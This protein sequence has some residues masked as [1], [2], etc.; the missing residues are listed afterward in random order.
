MALIPAGTFQM[1]SNDG[2]ED[3]RPVHAVYL[4][5]FYMDVY[6]V[7]NAQYKKFLDATP[8]SRAPNQWNNPKFN[9]SN[10]PVVGVTWFEAVSYAEWVGERLPTEA[11][12]EK[13][14]RGG[15]IGKQYP[16]GDNLTHNNANFIGIGA[17][18]IWDDQTSPVGSFPPNGYGLYD[19]IGNVWEWCSGWYS[20]IYYV[21]SP[22]QNPKGPGSGNNR[23]LRGSFWL[24]NIPVDLRVS[25]R[26]KD[27]P[28]I[29]NPSVGFRCV[30]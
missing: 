17:N 25:G 22:K 16:W 14:A 4:D 13:A 9:A 21:N 10:Q 28:A 27:I 5:A 7:T 12:W 20:G 6:E 19:M 24:H 23:V 15:L 18:D 8:G 2:R 26:W 30:R 3:E 29:D 1:G 11:E